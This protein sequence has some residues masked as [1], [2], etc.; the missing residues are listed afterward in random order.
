M[1]AGTGPTL[2]SSVQRAL[3]LLDAVNRRAASRPSACSRRAAVRIA[4]R[5]S[6]ISH[7]RTAR[8]LRH[9]TRFTPHPFSGTAFIGLAAGRRGEAAAERQLIAVMGVRQ[10]GSG[11][12]RA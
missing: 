9:P 3:H 4:D 6:H 5:L 8:H 7:H 2:I 12:A 10:G 1:M 11:G